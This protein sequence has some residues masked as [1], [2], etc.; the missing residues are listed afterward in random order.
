[1]FD[2]DKKHKFDYS[3]LHKKIKKKMCRKRKVSLLQNP[4]TLRAKNGIISGV[5]RRNSGG[6]RIWK[7]RSGMRAA[8]A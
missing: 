5:Y 4:L 6:D 8:S 1:M 2:M 7:K 3:K